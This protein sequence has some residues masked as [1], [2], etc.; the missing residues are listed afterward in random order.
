MIDDDLS[1]QD[2]E[3]REGLAKA[4]RAQQVKAAEGV[5]HV[6]AQYADIV[7]WWRKAKP[8]FQAK[9]DETDVELGRPD[10]VAI[11]MYAVASNHT[12]TDLA[13]MLAAKIVDEVGADR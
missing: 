12:A 10:Q 4:I 8:R 2:L 13:M 7:T 9:A 1:D 5:T 11:V 6:D 3:T